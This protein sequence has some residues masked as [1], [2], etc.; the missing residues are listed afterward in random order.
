MLVENV[1]CNLFVLCGL[2]RKRV[3]GRLTVETWISNVIELLSIS[4]SE[5]VLAH[6]FT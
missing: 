4:T 1:A 6:A 5:H 2:K 3:R